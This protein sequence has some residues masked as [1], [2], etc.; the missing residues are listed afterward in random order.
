MHQNAPLRPAHL[1]LQ[2]RRRRRPP[3]TQQRRACTHA[4]CWP[5][6]T[7]VSAPPD[8]DRQPAMSG[9]GGRPYAAASQRHAALHAEVRAEASALTDDGE[10]ADCS[11]KTTGCPQSDEGETAVV[12][13]KSGCLRVNEY[14]EGLTTRSELLPPPQGC[15]VGARL[16]IVYRG[17]CAWR[18]RRGANPRQNGGPCIIC[19]FLEKKLVAAT[20]TAC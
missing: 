16:A 9:I 7:E 14:K 5:S 20:H 6:K 4:S 1:M 8:D 11:C 12:A 15:C 13:A 10:E 18:R 3:K 19:P 2:L 17:C